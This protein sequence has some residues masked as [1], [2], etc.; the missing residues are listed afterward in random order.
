MA[1]Y[2]NRTPFM[3]SKRRVAQVYLLPEEWAMIE[4]AR[5]AAGMERSEFFRELALL[6][7]QQNTKTTPE[8]TVEEAIVASE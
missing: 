7:C 8:T 3:F 1:V 6:Y 4:K 2:R 5:S